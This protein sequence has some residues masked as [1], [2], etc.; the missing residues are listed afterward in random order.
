MTLDRALKLIEC[1]RSSLS[2]AVEQYTAGNNGHADL[3]VQSVR[4][5]LLKAES[6]IETTATKLRGVIGHD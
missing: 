4:S 2:I 3:W 6:I 5:D 1:A